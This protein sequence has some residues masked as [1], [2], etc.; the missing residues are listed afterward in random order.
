MR[1]YFSSPEYT[2]NNLGEGIYG[3][4][5]RLEQRGGWIDI[6][7]S[8]GQTW[9]LTVFIESELNRDPSRRESGELPDTSIIPNL[10]L[11]AN[12]RVTVILNGQTLLEN[13]KPCTGGLNAGDALL[14][15]GLNRLTL[16][17]RGGGDDIRLAA[18]LLTKFGAPVTGIKTHLTL[19]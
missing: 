6:P 12:C 19:D 4:M 1:D 10:W 13:G 16:L 5:L 8:A 7:D 11:D 18:W 2:L 17:C 9:F 14:Q 3:W 15:R